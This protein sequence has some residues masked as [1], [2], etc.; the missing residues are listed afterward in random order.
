MFT[1]K[2]ILFA[3]NMFV[4]YLLCVYKHVCSSWGSELLQALS[5]LHMAEVNFRCKHVYGSK[6]YVCRQ[7]VVHKHNTKFY[8]EPESNTNLAWTYWF[9]KVRD[10]IK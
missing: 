5:N 2:I 6:N 1:A 9:Y 10:A 7:G 3:V 8:C 4:G